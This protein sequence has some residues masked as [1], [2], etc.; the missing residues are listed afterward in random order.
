M[1][2]ME[3]NKPMAADRKKALETISEACETYGCNKVFAL[4]SG[5]DDSLAALRVAVEHPCFR[6]AVHC[7][8][9]IGV[10]ATRDFCRETCRNLRV[11]LIE[12][13]ATENVRSDG[14][15]D[16]QVYEQIVMEYGFPGPTKFGHGKMYNR[17]KER[18][19]RRL[20]REH[21]DGKERVVFASGCRSSES[22]RRMGNSERIHHGEPSRDGKVR[23]KRRVWVN[24]IIDWTKTDTLKFR[25][26][27]GLERNPVAALICKSGE[28]LC[29]GFGNEGELEELL[30]HDLTRPAGRH[31]LDLERRVIAAG[32]PWRWHERP[33]RLVSGVEEGGA[34]PLRDEPVPR[35]GPHVPGL[36]GAG[37]AALPGRELANHFTFG[38]HAPM[39]LGE[40]I[41]AR[42]KE[43]NWSLAD[44]S[45]RVKLSR[46]FLCEVELGKR[47]IGADSLASLSEA[48][49]IPMDQL[50]GRYGEEHPQA[51]AV[52]RPP[53][54]LPAALIAFAVAGNIPARSLLCLYWVQRTLNDHRLPP[55]RVEPE[56]F[57]WPKLWPAVKPFLED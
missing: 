53:L 24:H 47:R 43:L 12:Y 29:G 6:A 13:K 41:R 46:S 18:G 36:R 48:L 11:S 56:A 27:C 17:L 57:D 42:R 28:C 26:A 8:T 30:M 23:E 21:T 40:Q 20:M 9:G 3:T 4:F 2:Q 5:G 32:F 55:R 35:A 10:E 25:Q 14:T 45:A 15:P 16:P 7:N 49:G 54:H 33:P 37:R 50:M 22:V 39:T 1:P 51:G 44:L 31:L 19:L 52:T 38:G 34:V